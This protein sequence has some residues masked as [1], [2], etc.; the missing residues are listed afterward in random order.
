[1]IP[2]QSKQIASLQSRRMFNNYIQWV[3]VTY[4]FIDILSFQEY[5][6]SYVDTPNFNMP[7]SGSSLPIA[8]N[9]GVPSNFNPEMRHKCIIALAGFQGG[10]TTASSLLIFRDPETN[11]SSNIN[12][13]ESL[14]YD[15]AIY[16]IFC[17]QKCLY[18]FINI[19]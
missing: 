1:M 9:F 4:I 2:G 5:V 11:I 13:I 8:H 19:T 15:S 16:Q 14:A 17:I 12:S 3:Q 7:S 10:D 6:G 18:G